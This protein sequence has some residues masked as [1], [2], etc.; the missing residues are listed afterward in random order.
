M[1][2][3]VELRAVLT[4]DDGGQLTLELTSITPEDAAL[5]DRLMRDNDIFT[6][7]YSTKAYKKDSTQMTFKV[8]PGPDFTPTPDNLLKLMRWRP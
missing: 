8:Y 4:E 2:Q 1:S 6:L 3:R 5:L 7:A